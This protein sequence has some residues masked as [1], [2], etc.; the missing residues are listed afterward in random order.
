MTHLLKFLAMPLAFVVAVVLFASPSAPAAFG[1]VGG[2]A[3]AQYDDEEPPC[4][5]TSWCIPPPPPIPETPPPEPEPEPEEV[6]PEVL[7][8]CQPAFD[9]QGVLVGVKGACGPMDVDWEILCIIAVANLAVLSLGRTAG[10]LGGVCA[11]FKHLS[12]Q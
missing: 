12:E 1:L 9:P 3:F 10:A 8:S 4:E 7:Y 2:S 5:T 6:D 11:A